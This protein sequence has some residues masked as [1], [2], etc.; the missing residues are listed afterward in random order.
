MSSN[1]FKLIK[2][3]KKDNSKYSPQEYFEYLSDGLNDWCDS[4]ESLTNNIKKDIHNASMTNNM[5]HLLTIHERM[6][7][8]VQAVIEMNEKIKN[9]Q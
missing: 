1:V 6:S 2:N 9:D 7:G 8:I 3:K 4:I 5:V